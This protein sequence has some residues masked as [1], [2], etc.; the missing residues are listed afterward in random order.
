MKEAKAVEASCPLEDVQLYDCR[1][2]GRTLLVRELGVS[3]KIAEACINQSPDRAMSTRYDVGDNAADVRR[4][5][6]LWGEEVENM[7]C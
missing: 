1:R 3:F 4:A 2:F 6:D 7:T 5:M